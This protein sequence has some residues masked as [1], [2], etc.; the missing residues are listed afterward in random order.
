MIFDTTASPPSRLMMLSAGSMSADN[1]RFSEITVKR[2]FGFS[3]LPVFLIYRKMVCMDHKLIGRTLTARGLSKSG[4]ADALGVG[5]SAVTALLKGERRLLADEVP[6]AKKYL[7][8]DTVPVVGKVAA[9]A[10]M[11][12][13]ADTGEWD[14]VPAPDDAN[15]NTVAAE[16]EGSSLGPLFDRWL[17]FYDR[18]ERPVSRALFKKLCV[19]GTSDGQTLVKMLEP[20]KTK[21]LFHL[22]SNTEAPMLDV[23]IDWA[24]R[25]KHMVPR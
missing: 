14:R 6:K 2:Y 10:R 23:Q 25:V 24:A 11:I 20:S 12:F 3:K 16:I 9:G 19:I 1:F 22:Y 15:E 13:F 7:N 17:V 8:L 21:G 4:L 18:V 5:N